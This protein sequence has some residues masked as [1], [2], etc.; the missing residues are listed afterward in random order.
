MIA[1][2]K[3][4]DSITIVAPGRRVRNYDVDVALQYFARWGLKVKLGT[5]LFSDRH[6]YLSGTD[7]ER[8]ADMQQALDDPTC[9]A[10]VCARGGYGTT[11]VVDRLDFTKFKANPKWVVGFSDIT[12]LHLRLL[13][14][15][16]PSIH[17]TMPIMAAKPEAPAS[18][19]SLHH[20]LMGVPEELSAPYH[21][22]NCEGS[23][24]GTTIGGNLSLIV[25]ALGTATEPDTA[26]KIL[27]IEEIDEYYYKLDRMMVQ[28]KRA[29]KLEPL[30]GLVVGYMTD[31]KDTEPRFNETVEDIVRYHVRD[32][33]F[34]VGFG[35]CIGHQNPNY[36]FV[37][38]ARM[39][40][41]VTAGQPSTLTPV[42]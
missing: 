39:L 22:Q 37:H 28:L 26:G 9:A 40:L 31:I 27:V 4:G 41:R 38:N 23:I 20:A 25:D 30:G 3:S 36:A 6:N 18:F 10:V 12:A 2:V 1:P 33:T 14:E 15:G 42:S 17:G 19:Q 13:K 29:G 11:R 16:M 32:Y 7:D 21:P 24:E 35:F 8:L 34:P 5:N